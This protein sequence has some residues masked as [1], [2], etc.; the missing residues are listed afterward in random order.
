MEFL[1]FEC[2]DC[3]LCCWGSGS[4]SSG[5]ADLKAAQEPFSWCPKSK[6][7]SHHYYGGL[8]NQCLCLPLPSYSWSSGSCSY[9]GLE[10]LSSNSFSCIW[11]YLV[12]RPPSAALLPCDTDSLSVHTSCSQGHDLPQPQRGIPVPMDLL[13]CTLSWELRFSWCQRKLL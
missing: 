10:K 2:T 12:C 6:A 1:L 3:P 8:W 13:S 4:A 11:C 5:S 7:C 9:K